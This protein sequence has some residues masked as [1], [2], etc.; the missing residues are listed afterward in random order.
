MQSQDV[1]NADGEDLTHPTAEKDT[2]EERPTIGEDK[3]EEELGVKQK[4]LPP[5]REV[6]IGACI[7]LCQFTQM[8]PYGA[9]V[10]S[11]FLIGDDLGAGPAEVV[12]IVAA[13]PWVV[14]RLSTRT[15]RLIFPD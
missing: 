7:I 11:A 12:W 8:I 13:Y 9:G 5:W 14:S 6:L 3:S 10:N 2:S 15:S 4:P 1:Q